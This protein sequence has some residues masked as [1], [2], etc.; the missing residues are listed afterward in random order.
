MK[1]ITFNALRGLVSTTTGKASGKATDKATS[2]ALPTARMLRES[3]VPII[4]QATL[5]DATLTVYEN[6]FC[7]YSTPIGTTVYAVD[8]CGD[9]TYDGGDHLPEEMFGEEDWMVRLLLEGEDRLEHNN[10]VRESGN[11]FSYSADTTERDDL[12]DPYDFV[13]DLVNR[14]LVERMLAHLTEKQRRVVRMCLLCGMT[15]QQAA[16]CLGISKQ[17]VTKQI[18]AAIERFQK[19]FS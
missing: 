3:G 1:R 19:I 17:A 5:K 2:K 15:H 7:A 10:D 9:Y 16:D 6:G 14:D 13:E 18:G 12:R 8:R 4:A 11:H